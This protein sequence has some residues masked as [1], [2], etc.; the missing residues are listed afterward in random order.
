MKRYEIRFE[1]AHGYTRAVVQ[2]ETAEAAMQQAK[3]MDAFEAEFGDTYDMSFDALESISV[4]DEY[5]GDEELVYFE[6]E[7]LLKMHAHA[8][9]EIAKRHRHLLSEL[10]GGNSYSKEYLWHALTETE[11]ALS[12]AGAA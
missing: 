10:H 12:K 9:L 7:T 11:V 8:L 5:T 3:L 6:P 1:F 2:A 4:R